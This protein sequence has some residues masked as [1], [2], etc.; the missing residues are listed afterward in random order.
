ML[1]TPADFLVN[2]CFFDWCKMAST[3][4][5]SSCPTVPGGSDLSKLPCCA[6][7]MSAHIES[8]RLQ[9]HNACAIQLQVAIDGQEKTPTV[10]AADKVLCVIIRSAEAK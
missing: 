9:Y 3:T 4:K 8:E 7:W 5:S 6:D 2:L 1:F 10:I